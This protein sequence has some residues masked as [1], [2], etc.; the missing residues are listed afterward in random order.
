LK[1]YARNRQVA[2]KGEHGPDIRVRHNEYPRY[3]IVEAK[4][5]AN[6]KTVENLGARREVA[7]LLA[8]GQIVTRMDTKAAYHYGL[9]LPGSFESKVKIRLPWLFCKANDLQV[10]L[11]DSQGK[12]RAVNWHHLK[13]AQPSR[14]RKAAR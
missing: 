14:S 3:F 6:P 9:A 4:G 8:L 12:V 1:G 10:L 2:G 7:F 11:V 13:A 5:D